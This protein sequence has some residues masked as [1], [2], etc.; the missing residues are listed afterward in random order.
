MLAHH[1]QPKV[2]D[3]IASYSRER[4]IK[5]IAKLQHRLDRLN[6]PKYF[7]DIEWNF[8]EHLFVVMY[9]FG[10]GFL[11]QAASLF[12]ATGAVP[13]N[14]FWKPASWVWNPLP[15]VGNHLPEIAVAF[16]FLGILLAGL[17]MNKSAPLRPSKRPKLRLEI[18]TQIDALKAKL[19]EFDS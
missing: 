13:K 2:E 11:A 4:L 1:Y 12:L 10:T 18:Q 8:R 7:E 3:Y 19:D 15:F 6:D 5:R 14:W 9:L 16:F 17:N